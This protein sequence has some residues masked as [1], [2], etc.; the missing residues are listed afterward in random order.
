MKKRKYLYR[1]ILIDDDYDYLFFF[2]YEFVSLLYFFIYRGLDF[3]LILYFYDVLLFIF[4]GFFLGVFLCVFVF[5]NDLKIE[6]FNE[7]NLFNLY[8]FLIILFIFKINI[9][10]C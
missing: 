5:G 1:I 8:V 3:W 4:I 2:C 7:K 9:I 6:Y 10:C